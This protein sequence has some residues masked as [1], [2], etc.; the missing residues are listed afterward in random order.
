[1]ANAAAQIMTKLAAD[2]KVGYS[3]DRE[4]YCSDEIGRA[5]V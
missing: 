3:F 2:T 5:H 4:F 1:M